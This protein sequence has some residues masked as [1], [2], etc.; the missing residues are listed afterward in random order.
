[1]TATSSGG[2]AV[3]TGRGWGHGVGMIQWGAYGKALRGW[4]SARILAYYYG[5]LRP[6]RYPEPGLIHVEVANGLLSVRMRASGSG[7]TI[8]GRELGSGPLVITGGDELT[9]GGAAL[10]PA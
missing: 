9:L 5:G 6:R 1:M 10:S 2:A 7:A 3:V 8:D 4:S